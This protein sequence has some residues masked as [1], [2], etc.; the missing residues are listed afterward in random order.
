MLAS[1]KFVQGAVAK[2]DFVPALNH[3]RIE[4]GRIKGYNGMIALCS[5]IDLNLAITPR[6][7][8]FVK[9]IEACTDTISMHVTDKGR[10]SIK[11]GRFKAFV[12]C[13][14]DPFPNVEPEGTKIQLDG[15]F[16]DTIKLLAQFIAED[17]SRPWARGIL[18]YGTSAYALNNV[19]L[20][21]HWLGYNFPVAINVPKQA[22]AELLRIDEEPLYLQWNGDSM[23]FH[24]SG[25]RWLRTQLLSLEWPDITNVLAQEGTP[26]PFPDTLFEAIETLLPFVEEIPAVHFAP[27]GSI[28]TSIHDGQGASVHVEPFGAVGSYNIHQLLLLAGVAKRIDLSRE[29]KPAPF[30]GANLRG[31]IIGMRRAQ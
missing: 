6:A 26:V 17:A 9:A 15:K 29:S 18:F 3:F 28:S 16:L 24:F 8:P 30:H 19:I 14:E 20:V 2:K 31:V 22:V 11:S 10:L 25:D 5:P 13:L 21:E 23:T 12:D 1:L 7:V 4:G 27:D